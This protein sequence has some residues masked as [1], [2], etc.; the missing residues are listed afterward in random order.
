[1]QIFEFHTFNKITEKIC[2]KVTGCIY[3][4]LRACGGKF[5]IVTREQNF[6]ENLY[7]AHRQRHQ[8]A[9]RVW[10]SDYFNFLPRAQQNYP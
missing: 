9:T 1:M 8:N 10:W 2:S 3:Y 4:L 5:K 7:A 6:N